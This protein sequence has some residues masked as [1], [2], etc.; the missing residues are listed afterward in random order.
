[1]PSSNDNSSRTLKRNAN[2][3]AV[4]MKGTKSRRQVYRDQV[5]Y[6]T[7]A[8]YVSQCYRAVWDKANRK[9]I[10]G[11]INIHSLDT[12]FPSAKKKKC[13]AN[14]LM[15]VAI[16]WDTAPCNPYMSRRFGGT[17]HFQFQGPKSACSTWLGLSADR[18]MRPSETSVHIRT[19]RRYIPEDGNI[20]NYRCENLKSYINRLMFVACMY[21]VIIK[22]MM[23]YD[24]LFLRSS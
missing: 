12:S 3:R 18:G 17:Y 16:F 4:N 22:E 13:H 21:R 20:H 15:K 14:R 24:M 10:K 6:Y 5:Q 1:M 8:N 7:E 19:T 2:T 11:S 9:H 23:V